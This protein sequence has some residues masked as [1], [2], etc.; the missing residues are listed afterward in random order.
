MTVVRMLADDL[1][2][3]VDTIC[4]FATVAEPIP[5]FW[6]GGAL[7]PVSGSFALD[8]ETREESDQDAVSVVANLLPALY[9]ADVAFKKLDS[10]LRG[11]PA[12]EIAACLNAGAFA[13]IVIAP[14]F[15]DQGR[16]TRNGRQ[17]ILLGAGGGLQELECDLRADLT[18]LGLVV[19][20][21]KCSDA[22][23]KSGIFVC[24][25]ETNADL[26]RVVTAGRGLKPPILWC[27]SSGL[28]RALSVRE[29]NESVPMPAMPILM[30]IGS[31][32]P[33]SIAQVDALRQ[34]RPEVL[35]ILDSATPDENAKSI[36]LMAHCLD[37]GLASTLA[38]RFTA[39]T[40]GSAAG[41][42]ISTTLS[43]AVE[44]LPLPGS[45]LVTGG[46]TLLRFVGSTGADS[47]LVSGELMPGVPV[48]EL[49]GGVWDALTVVSK[50]G[51]FGKAAS[52]CDL[53]ELFEGKNHA[54]A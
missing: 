44:R 4:P 19:Q 50:S 30:I 16:I 34:H 24:D 51:A 1:T 53:L 6:Q 40:S 20:R 29:A 35:T 10:L 14:A 17:F 26:E 36:E 37:Q 15:P 13:S 23:N 7:P 52:L 3:A 39:N 32:H 42:A 8:T 12:A 33:S 5:V 43:N 9:S 2:G 28:A 54:T 38:F 45:V 31:D 46:D 22:V 18:G 21:A 25:A 49:S 47:L 48:S 11:H 41:Q 27:G